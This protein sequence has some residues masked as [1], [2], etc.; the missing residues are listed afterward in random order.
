MNKT[1]ANSGAARELRPSCQRQLN[2]YVLAAVASGVAVSA[3]SPSAEAKIIYS[4]AHRV[5]GDGGRYMLDLNGDRITDLTFINKYSHFCTTDGG[6]GQSQSLA[7]NM[8]EGNRVVRN[9][10][11]AVALKTGMPISSKRS[12][13]G[14][15]QTMARLLGLSLSS[16]PWGSWVNVK[17]RY[18][19]VKFKIKGK[20]H[21]GWARLSVR[22]QFPM[23]ITATL[24]GYAYE[25]VPNRPIIAGKT[26]GPDVIERQATL[27]ELA[28]GRK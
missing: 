4:L 1:R 2:S 11:G 24:T 28:L 22:I 25:T 10:W 9:M 6:C 14:G 21:Y 15:K 3:L 7:A 19:G 12:F 20:I 23:T 18:L 17:N 8:A 13:G 16:T 26:K 27:G 5:I